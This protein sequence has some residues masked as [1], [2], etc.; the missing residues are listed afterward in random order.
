MNVDALNRQNIPYFEQKLNWVFLI[1]DAKKIEERMCYDAYWELY[2][3]L[4]T[5]TLKMYDGLSKEE[6]LIRCGKCR[7]VKEL[8]EMQPKCFYYD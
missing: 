7:T 8:L 3:N 6:F 5:I 1:Q 4:G 2:T